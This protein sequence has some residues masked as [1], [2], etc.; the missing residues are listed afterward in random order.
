M[1]YEPEARP[2]YAARDSVRSRIGAWWQALPRWAA[3]L[4]VAIP[5]LVVAVAAG[6]RGEWL[7]VAVLAALSTSHLVVTLYRKRP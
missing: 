5:V 6:L 3:L 1:P 2:V 4:V 7:P